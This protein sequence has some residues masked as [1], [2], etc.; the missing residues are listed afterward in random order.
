MSETIFGY[1]IRP[2]GGYFVTVGTRHSKRIPL[3]YVRKS[4]LNPRRWNAYAISPKNP[5][6]MHQ[7][8]GPH[9]TQSFESRS[10][11]VRALECWRKEHDAGP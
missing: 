8:S 5:E 6:V 2:E 7:L 4:L 11:A 10:A 9:V 3:G 1:I